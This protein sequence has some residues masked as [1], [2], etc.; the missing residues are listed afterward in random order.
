M[1][2]PE[3]LHEMEGATCRSVAVWT[4]RVSP[5]GRAAQTGLIDREGRLANGVVRAS[6][7]LA[8]QI[9]RAAPVNDDHEASSVTFR[10]LPL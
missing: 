9:S 6:D 3:H 1:E 7:D 5:M 2:G 10:G 4:V 8:V